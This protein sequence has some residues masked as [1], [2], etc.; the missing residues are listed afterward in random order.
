ML[1]LLAWLALAMALLFWLD[2]RPDRSHASGRGA[3]SWNGP[4]DRLTAILPQPWAP[5]VAR[6]LRF[7][8]RNYQVQL[9]FVG[10]MFFVGVM[11]LYM[12][13]RS[14]S[15]MAPFELTMLVV[16]VL[17]TVTS[18]L[19]P[20]AFGFEGAGARRL[21]LAPVERR[22]VLGSMN[23]ASAIICGAYLL[24]A[25]AIW[26]A[27]VAPSPRMVL[28]LLTHGMS[29]LLL[30]HAAALWTS[31]LMPVRADYFEKFRKQQSGGTRITMVMLM[32]LMAV[33]AGVRQILMPG[34]LVN[35][36]W[37]SVLVMTACAAAYAASFGPAAALFGRRR[38]RMLAIVEGRA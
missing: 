10:L 5:L 13:R 3:A 30:F 23:L 28:M 2:R 36:W 38:E 32:A 29:G 27:F 7:Y 8:L 22:M 25:I 20:N 6:G 21:L 37:V 9:S 11:P 4:I 31:V 14:T 19:T 1:V 12:T 17:G 33:S 18:A 34:P 16:L 35:Y 15:P 24:L 26:S